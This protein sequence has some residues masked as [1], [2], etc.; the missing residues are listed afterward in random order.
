MKEPAG[1]CK[2]VLQPHSASSPPGAP[3]L[4]LHLCPHCTV[5]GGLGDSQPGLFCCCQP[6]PAGLPPTHPAGLLPAEH[7]A[8]SGRPL[9]LRPALG[10]PPPGASWAVWRCS[11]SQPPPSQFQVQLRTLLHSLGPTAWDAADLTGLNY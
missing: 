4:L 9:R 11:S 8:F 5:L 3:H 10:H 6:S 7:L 1:N 2:V